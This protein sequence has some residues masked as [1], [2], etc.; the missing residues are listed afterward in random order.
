MKRKTKVENRRKWVETHP[1]TVVFL[2]NSFIYAIGS[3]KAPNTQKKQDLP[4]G[5]S[6][7][8]F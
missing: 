7:V 6:P 2:R 1:V 3:T 5:E 4:E 8:S